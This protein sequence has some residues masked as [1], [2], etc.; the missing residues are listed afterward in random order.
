MLS[1]N[2]IKPNNWSKK[3]SKRVG[4]WMVLEK[5]HIHEDEW[6]DKIQDQVVEWGLGLKVDKHLYSEECLNWNDFQTLTLQLDIV[7]LTLEI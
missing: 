6:M 7:L 2:N 3:V 1:L 5:E 4:R